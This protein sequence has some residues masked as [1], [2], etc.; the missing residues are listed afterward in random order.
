MGQYLLAKAVDL[1]AQK[2]EKGLTCASKGDYDKGKSSLQ[3]TNP[4]SLTTEVMDSLSNMVISIYL[5][6]YPLQSTVDSW[7]NHRQLDPPRTENERCW[8]GMTR[9][10][11]A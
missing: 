11:K 6:L 9:A 2:G 5:V 7:S 10:V 4:S 1:S 8:D 3:S